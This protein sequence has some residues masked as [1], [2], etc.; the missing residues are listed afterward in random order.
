MIFFKLADLNSLKYQLS[1]FNKKRKCRIR[2]EFIA[3]QWQI[4]KHLEEFNTH[5]PLKIITLELGYYLSR[6]EERRR[7]WGP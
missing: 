3:L 6:S 1:S 5:E 2:P 4:S 7:L